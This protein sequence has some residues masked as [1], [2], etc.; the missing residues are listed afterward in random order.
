MSIQ[1]FPGHMLKA[2]REAA[3]TMAKTDV[4]IEVLDARV[5]HSSLNPGFEAM[6]AKRQ[7]PAL[8]LLNKTDA[9][10]PQRTRAWLA[11][12]NAMPGVK[13]LAL[14]ARN[15]GE[16]RRIPDAARALAP[17]RGTPGKPLRMMILGAPNVGKSTLMNALLGRKL[18][19]VGNEPAIT[20]SQMRH[21]LDPTLI[22]VDTPGMTWPRIPAPSGVRLAAAHILGRNAY[23]ELSV[24]LE[25]GAYLLSDY[26]ALLEKRYGKRPDDVD[27]HTLLEWIGRARGLLVKG[28]GVDV[29]KAAGLLLN[30]FRS[31]ALGRITLETPEQVAGWAAEAAPPPDEDR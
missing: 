27:A 30:E 4:V 26:P 13:A 8:K 16:V 28:G 11:H 20:K 9:A 10:D 14:S 7:R 18:A 3:E 15:A 21:E 6:R 23:D 22:L 1:W 17:H 5:P 24:A 31:G 25:F 19:K 2:R 12:Y 29:E